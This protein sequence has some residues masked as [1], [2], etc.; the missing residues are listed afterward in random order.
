MDIVIVLI[1]I[2]AAALYISNT[3]LQKF[4]AAQSGNDD[5]KCSSCYSDGACNSCPSDKIE[6]K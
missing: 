5:C 2:T 1:I 6:F 4:K 3:F